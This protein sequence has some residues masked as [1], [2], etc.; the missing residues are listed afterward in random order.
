L[1]A[2]HRKEIPIQSLACSQVKEEE[3]MAWEQQVR[4]ERTAKRVSPGDL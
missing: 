4:E 1:R 2:W 3:P